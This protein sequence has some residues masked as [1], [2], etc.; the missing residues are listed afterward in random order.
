MANA[1]SGGGIIVQTLGDLENGRRSNA[2]RLKN[3]MVIPTLKSA[4][5]GDLSLCL[6]KRQLDNII[7]TLHAID[8][9]IPGT[10]NPDTLLYGVEAKYYSA[11][12]QTTNEFEMFVDDIGGYYAM[13]DGA[14]FTRSLSQACAQ[15]LMVADILINKF[16]GE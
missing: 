10:A 11:R 7:E 9:A 15:G 5:A 8:K 4:V 3:N 6:P 13:G 12:P 2:I 14:G 16:K 1:I